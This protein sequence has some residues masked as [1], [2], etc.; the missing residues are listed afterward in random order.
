M[1]LPTLQIG[2]LMSGLDTN[3]II[4]GLLDVERIPVQQLQSRRSAYQAK[5]TAWQTINTRYSAIRSALEGLESAG[6]FDVFAAATS[7]NES[8]VTVA[9]GGTAQPGTVSFTVDRLAANHQ[10][11]STT[12]FTGGSDLVA[13]GDFTITIDGTDH[14]VTADG[15]GTL[16]D[17]AAEINALEIGVAASVISV[18][19][20]DHRLMLSAD[21]TGNDAAF[22]T[23][24]T[25]ASLAS[26]SVV[27][28]GVDA[29]LTLGSGAGALTIS[30]P[31]NSIAD[32]V[33]GVTIDLH[34]TTSSSVTVAVDRDV[35]AAVEQIT[36]LVDAL[37]EAMSSMQGYTAYS[38]ETESGGVL[39]GDGTVRNLMIDLRSAV[40]SAV[41]A[42][43]SEYATAGTIGISL[44]RDGDFT[45]DADSLRSALESDFDAVAGFFD[46]AGAA[47]DAALDEAEGATGK[48]ARARDLWQSQIDAIDD[49]IEVLEDRIERREA[50]LIRQF[51]GLESAMATLTSQAAWLSAQLG[52][53]AAEG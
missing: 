51:A 35:D 19:G 50:A 7:S 1:T 38:A 42:S 37:N 2:G 47:L 27:Q 26:T 28:E 20:T 21:T 40:S 25:I 14:T 9:A 49:R 53:Q 44:T 30:R 18:D 12:S 36:E 31:S 33:A 41:N 5:D 16:A 3:S 4:D 48:I 32:L 17:L 24:S 29:E 52:A 13:A 34:A 11:V 43:S 23:S 39:V 10:V 8:A 45:L 46:V 15:A 6:D 22:T